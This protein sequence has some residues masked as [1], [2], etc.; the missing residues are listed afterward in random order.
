[1]NDVFTM[2][3]CEV[4]LDLNDGLG[5]LLIQSSNQQGR[6]HLCLDQPPAVLRTFQGVRLGIR[7]DLA[8][9]EDAQQHGDQHGPRKS[10]GLHQLLA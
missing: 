7:P 10:G 1:M 3:R 4:V 5:K 2:P 8:P 6:R 9:L